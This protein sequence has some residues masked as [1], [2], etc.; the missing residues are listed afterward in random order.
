MS[1]SS[2]A[3]VEPG[4]RLLNNRHVEVVLADGKVVDLRPPTVAEWRKIL[5]AFRLA[6]D[7]LAGSEEGVVLT[8]FGEAAPF[9]TALSVAIDTLSA[10]TVKPDRLP[11]WA[12]QSGIVATLWG[13]WSQMAVEVEEATTP[14][15][16]LPS[17]DPNDPLGVGP[18]DLAEL[19]R[20]NT[21]DG[22][23]AGMR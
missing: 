15:P 8:M 13:H 20:M 10:S 19:E 5:E 23:A 18:I 12:G 14:E 11:V 9:A 7:I 22:V 6:E 16:A 21:G 3:G 17:Y 1:G 2:V 4:L